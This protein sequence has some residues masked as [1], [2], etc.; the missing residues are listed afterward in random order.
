MLCYFIIEKPKIPKSFIW[1]WA[2]SISSMWTRIGAYKMPGDN[3]E[4]EPASFPS[5]PLGVCHSAGVPYRVIFNLCSSC[6][7]SRRTKSTSSLAGCVEEKPWLG[8][9]GENWIA[10]E[11]SNKTDLYQKSQ[12]IKTE[13]FLKGVG[14]YESSQKHKQ[15]YNGSVFVGN[16]PGFLPARLL[17]SVMRYWKTSVLWICFSL[18]RPACFGGVEQKMRAC[19]R[20][21][22][23]Q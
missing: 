17:F 22:G 10:G 3:S 5:H 21:C 18:W 1:Q 12:L 11:F 23:Q 13:I 2:S 4:L 8:G 20:F 14:F 16:L 15:S 9:V 7:S 19:M 6:G